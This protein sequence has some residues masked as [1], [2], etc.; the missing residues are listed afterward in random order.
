MAE[1]LNSRTTCKKYCCTRVGIRA[2]E[3]Y[4]T[5]TTTTSDQAIPQNNMEHERLEHERMERERREH[6]R[7]QQPGCVGS[8]PMAPGDFASAVNTIK[9][10]SFDDTKL[11]TA[12]QIAG[13]NC[14]SAGQI[15]EICKTFSFEDKKLDFA[16]FAYTHCTEP[17]NYFKINNVF[18]FSSSVDDLNKYIQ[19][20]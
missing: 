18:T 15:A 10:E 13:G 1:A 20:K 17:N 2:I 12:K 4:C 9:K 3:G 16:K 8:Y 14:L 19:S 5:T 11:S 7:T 6:E